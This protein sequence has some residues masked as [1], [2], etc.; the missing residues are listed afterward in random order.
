LIVPAN[1]VVNQASAGSGKVD[2]P[3][4]DDTL[5]ALLLS[6]NEYPWLFVVKSS[7][8]TSQLFNTFPQLVSTA[9]N[10]SSD[11]VKTYGLMVYQPASWNGNE[12]SLLTQ[13]LAYIPSDKFDTLNAYIKTQGSPLFSQPGIQ[14][15][16]A[17][18][19]NT[20]FPL[21]ASTGNGDTTKGS[22]ESS[23]GSSD[24]KRNII[25]GV[26]VSIGGLLWIALVWWIYKR[27]KRSNDKAVHKRLSEH[28]SMFDNGQYAT[29]GANRD[30]HRVSHVPS[31]AASDVDDR[32]SSF[33]ASP[34]DN[35]RSMRAMQRDN[36]SYH[37]EDS[38]RSAPIG[39]TYGRADSPTNYGPSV[40][41]TSW[42]AQPPQQQQPRRA[43]PQNPF[44]DIVTRSYLGT[45]GSRDGLAQ[46]SNNNRRSQGIQKAMIGQPHLQG[47]SLEFR[48]RDYE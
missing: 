8:A 39:A 16:L 7:D 35:D 27:V 23:G 10:I 5:I 15:Q 38:L 18:Q 43:Q 28:M 31:I 21:A 24:K 26:C 46:M 19:I 32:P 11:N 29:Y 14:G 48:D 3:V 30:S 20:A 47:N 34:L 42:F 22:S 4:K 9:L 41:G 6:E 12:A 25:I 17:A 36:M 37:G 40:F 1:S 33:Y 44:E 13:W 45:S 2:D